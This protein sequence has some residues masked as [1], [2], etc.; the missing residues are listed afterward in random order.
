MNQKQIIIR[1]QT[2]LQLATGMFVLQ[3]VVG[4]VLAR[5]LN[6]VMEQGSYLADIVSRNVENLDEFDLIALRDL[7][8]LK[9]TSE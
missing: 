5:Q 7:G 9:T 3:G 6:K 1:R 4:I 8:V 2:L